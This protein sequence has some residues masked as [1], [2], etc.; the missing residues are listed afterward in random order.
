M[1]RA[2]GFR[3]LRLVAGPCYEDARRA[4]TFTAVG[5][6]TIAASPKGLPNYAV[7]EMLALSR[8]RLQGRPDRHNPKFGRLIAEALTVRDDWA[9]AGE[10]GIYEAVAHVTNFIQ[11]IPK[12]AINVRP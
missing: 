3:R 10:P 5:R 11:S 4:A 6:W 8:R 2:S 12:D 9:Q 7:S 1:K